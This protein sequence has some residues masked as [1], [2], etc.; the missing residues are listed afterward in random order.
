MTFAYLVRFPLGELGLAPGG[1]DGA[2]LFIVCMRS[3]P[4]W[5]QEDSQSASGLVLQTTYSHTAPLSL[6][7]T[8]CS[9]SGS[10]RSERAV[11]CSPTASSSLRQP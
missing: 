1:Q 10:G 3:A 4:A 9:G 5:R 11:P 7:H 2:F 8:A 6:G